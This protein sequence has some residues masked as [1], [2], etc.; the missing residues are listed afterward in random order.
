[1]EEW[2]GHHWDRWVRRRAG[3]G[4]P[5]RPHEATLAALR[6]AVEWLLRAGGATLRVAEACPRRVAGPRSA[7]QRLAGSGLRLPLPQ[8]DPQVL[9]LPTRVAVYPEAALNVDLYVWWAALATVFDA[10]RPWAPANAEARERALQ[11]FPGLA[12]RLQRLEAA[13]AGRRAVGWPADDATPTTSPPVWTWLWPCAPGELGG[14][15]A[16]PDGTDTSLATAE[17][18]AA[19]LSGRRQARH[20]SPETGRP[21]LL[22]AAKGESIK[23]FAD[24]P[25]L[26]RGHDDED[27][28]SVA[29][30]AE[31]I[32]TPT[33]VRQ[34]GRAPTRLRFDLDLPSAAADDEP[35]GPGLWLPEWDLATQR[36]R[37]RRVHAQ[38][39][40]AVS[41]P[42]WQPAPALRAEASR[43]R[44]RLEGQRAAL[45]WQRGAADGEEIDLDGVVR[46]AAEVSGASSGAFSGAACDPSGDAPSERG[47]YRRRVRAQREMATLLL[48]DLSLSTDAH[49]NDHQRVIDVIRDALY[50]F[51]QAL[52]GGGDAF[53]ITGFSS[54]KRRLRLHPL[55]DFDETWG[56]ATQ[57][58]LG[59]LRPGYYTRM[60]A[61]LRAGTRQLAARP[62]RR[63]LLLLLTDGKPHDLDGYDGRAGLEDTRQAV[64]EARQA[65]LLPFALTIADDAAAVMPLLF[66]S[67][68]GQGG[69]GWARV[70]R[71]EDLPRRLAGLYAQLLR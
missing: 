63:R 8:I 4:A 48:A 36:L 47:L 53:A 7:W 66:G 12:L 42:P 25:A 5:P 18:A 61:A 50:V 40:Q 64:R 23:T 15:T 54:V 44:R 19:A 28:G 38:P 11:C 39:L 51:G 57:A 67:T 55:K 49:A 26:D 32:E 70:Q 58:R 20:R 21:P 33:L 3:E 14:P 13:E 46:L 37:P 65:G 43:V 2:I 34:A 9:A 62:E 24:A 29:V 71:P 30:A 6:P 59:A 27:D 10:T 17:D 52:A 68:C 41:P 35:L 45:R 60:G 1:M 22:L 56:P 16:A 31:E 69:G